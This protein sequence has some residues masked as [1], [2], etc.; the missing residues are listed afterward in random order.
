MLI[1]AA[2]DIAWG[3]SPRQTFLNVPYCDD[4]DR[5]DAHVAIL[6]IPY[7]DPYSIDE[8]SNP[9]TKAPAA[10]R[11]ASIRVSFG[12]DRYDFDIGGTV[13]DGKDIKVV[14][15]GDIPGDPR[16]LSKH[17][18][19]AEAAVRKILAKG[20]LPIILGGDHGVPIPVFRAYEGRGPIHLVHIDA[21]LDFRDEVLGVKEGYSNPIRR[22]SELSHIKGITQI[23]L[24][25]QGSARPQDVE[26]AIAYGCDIITASELHDIGMK[27]VLDRIPENTN[28]YLTIDA[29]GVDPTVMP[30][31]WAPHPGGV[32][33]PQMHTL[34]HGLCRKGGVVGMDI[35]EIT[36]IF[37]INQSTCIAAGRFIVNLI[38]GAVRSGVF[39]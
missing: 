11:E 7:G 24:R 26:D 2:S 5:L 34:I 10:V 25:G 23:G 8:V 18:Q 19:L 12:L 14:D 35:N 33:Y 21:H 37:D 29:D 13:F 38:G 17:Y 1:P 39:D 31:V 3:P 32:T 4:L 20:A 28:Y 6:G 9:Q 30:G 22:A 27:S 16:D 15:C 36:P